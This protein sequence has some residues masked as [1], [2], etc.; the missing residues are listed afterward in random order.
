VEALVVEAEAS[1]AS[2]EAVPV[3]VVQAAVGSK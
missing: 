1:V 3:V 2:A